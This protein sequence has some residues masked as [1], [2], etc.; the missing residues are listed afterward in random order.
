MRT[1][2][3]IINLLPP[4]LYVGRALKLAMAAVLDALAPY[5]KKLIA[6]M[7]EEE[8]HILLGVSGEIKKLERNTEGLK[9]IPY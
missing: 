4:Q 9:K 7:T 5:V 3:K 8:V 1:Y 2:L 6:D